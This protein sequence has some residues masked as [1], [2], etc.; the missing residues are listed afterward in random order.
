VR[1]TIAIRDGRTSTETLRRAA[2]E[3]DDRVGLMLAIVSLSDHAR[4]R[5]NELSGGQQQRVAIARALAGRPRLLIADQPTGQLDSQTPQP[6]R[7]PSRPAPQPSR[8]PHASPA[9]ATFHTFGDADGD[10]SGGKMTR[11]CETLK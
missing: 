9:S 11:T 1:R 4:Q 6:S 2:D 5:P 7:P 8:L 3:R 10:E